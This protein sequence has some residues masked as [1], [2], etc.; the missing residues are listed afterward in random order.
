[1]TRVNAR[2]DIVKLA[3]WLRSLRP[4]I[5]LALRRQRNERERRRRGMPVRKARS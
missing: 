4:A 3:D 1:M 5:N 2:G